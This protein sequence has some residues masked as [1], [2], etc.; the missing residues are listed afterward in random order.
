LAI[1]TSGLGTPALSD[2]INLTISSRPAARPRGWCPGTT[3]AHPVHRYRR[4]VTSRVRDQRASHHPTSDYT[5]NCE[6]PVHVDREH[7][8][9][10][11][12]AQVGVL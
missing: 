1:S 3:H 11:C 5:L 6:E 8:V 12:F 7:L 2:S 9:E 10:P 4:I